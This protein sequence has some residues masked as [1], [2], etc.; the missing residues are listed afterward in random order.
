MS[1]IEE[2]GTDARS[3]DGYVVIFRYSKNVTGVLAVPAQPPKSTALRKL[4]K[5]IS[6]HESLSVV[7]EGFEIEP[8][9]VGRVTPAKLYEIKFGVKSGSEDKS[10]A[11]FLEFARQC[12]VLTNPIVS[13]VRHFK[14]K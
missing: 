9:S 11:L 2:I 6:T 10:I 3:A 13:D 7:L 5:V 1:T 14:L 4:K 8:R 12:C